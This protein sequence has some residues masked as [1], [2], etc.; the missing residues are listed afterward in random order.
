MLE[1]GM[2]FISK[3]ASLRDLSQKIRDVLDNR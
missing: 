1:E 3:P 2:H